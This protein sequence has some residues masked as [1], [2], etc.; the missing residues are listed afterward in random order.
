M[1]EKFKSISNKVSP[2]DNFIFNEKKL[3]LQYSICIIKPHVCIDP[4][5]T[6]QIID[7]LE[8]E[9]FEIRFVIQRPLDDREVANIY[10]K[11][12]E[13]EYFDD[14][15][16]NNSTGP[17]L[18]ML[19]SHTSSENPIQK[20]KE[21]TGP[22]DPEIAKSEFPES[23]RSK[24]GEDLMF[25]AVYCSDDILEANKE[26]DVFRFPIPQKAPEFKFDKWRISK[27]MILKFLQPSYIEHPNVSL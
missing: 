27:A 7:I 10:Y 3:N 22:M 15:I 24:F 20:L 18:V 23:L 5:Q 9:G 2:E 6:Q 21:L 19:L 26:R 11:H 13:E 17:S 14:L 1:T 12:A 25:N 8:T 4:Q 16:I